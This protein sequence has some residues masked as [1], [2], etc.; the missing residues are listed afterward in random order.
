M[1]VVSSKLLVVIKESCKVVIK[2]VVSSKLLVV[3]SSKLDKNYCDEFKLS[4]T[5]IFYIH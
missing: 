5:E 2:K 3:I 1:K 4:S